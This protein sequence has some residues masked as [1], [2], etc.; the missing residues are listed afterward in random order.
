M[1]MGA[2]RLLSATSCLNHSIPFLRKLSSS[3][4]KRVIEWVAGYV[5]GRLALLGYYG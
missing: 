4:P 2:D 1:V 3:L 5:S